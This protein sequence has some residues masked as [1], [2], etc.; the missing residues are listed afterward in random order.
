MAKVLAI[1]SLPI[2]Q[3]RIDLI[4]PNSYNPSPRDSVTIQNLTRDRKLHGPHAFAPILIYPCTC[5]RIK[6]KHFEL[7]DGEK[8]WF[9]LKTARD[10]TIGSQV[11]PVIDESSARS[12]AYRR[13]R[14][15]GVIDEFREA[16]LFEW[17]SKQGKTYREIADSYALTESYV[18]NRITLVG[19]P[20]RI[21]RIVPCGTFS[22]SMWE[23]V[24]RSRTEAIMKVLVKDIREDKFVRTVYEAER[25][26]T[27]YNEGRLTVA[28]HEEEADRK[29]AEETENKFQR[30]KELMDETQR[31]LGTLGGPVNRELLRDSQGGDFPFYRSDEEL[32]DRVQSILSCVEFSAKGVVGGKEVVLEKAE[33]TVRK[34][35]DRKRLEEALYVYV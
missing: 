29:D 13:A 11:L 6:R 7:N 27:W 33:L 30:S 34:V 35:L 9:V 26:V 23:V 21:R 22:G 17:E 3:I 19:I 28:S 15:H 4:H 24:A 14:E 32:I 5:K 25:R 31:V 2:Q 12:L 10:K 1:D 18:K 8:R 16:E 20:P